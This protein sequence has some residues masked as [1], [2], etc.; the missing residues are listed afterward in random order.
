MDSTKT[1]GVNTKKLILTLSNIKEV[2]GIL[3]DVDVSKMSQLDRL[4]LEQKCMRDGGVEVKSRTT[5][6]A[7]GESV[8]AVKLYNS[9][10]RNYLASY[11]WDMSE[12]LPV[13]MDRNEG[14]IIYS[15]AEAERLC[16]ILNVLCGV[17]HS[18]HIVNCGKN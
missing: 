6:L 3:N 11:M 12:S 8:Y 1:H 15:E 5:I 14:Y 13:S 10:M 9:V 16:R 18:W 7:F 17:L 2:Y 4:E